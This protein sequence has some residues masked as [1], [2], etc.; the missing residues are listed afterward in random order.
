MLRYKK[1]VYIKIILSNALL[2]EAER[3]EITNMNTL[4]S[5]DA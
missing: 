4:Y 3:N 5:E 2:N 1:V